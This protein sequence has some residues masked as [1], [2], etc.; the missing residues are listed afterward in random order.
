MTRQPTPC[1]RGPGPDAWPPLPE[2][3]RGVPSWVASSRSKSE[4]RTLLLLRVNRRARSDGHSHRWPWA[5]PRGDP[6]GDTQRRFRSRRSGEGQEGRT[7][8][9]SGKVRYSCSSWVLSAVLLRFLTSRCNSICRCWVA[10]TP[11]NGAPGADAPSPRPAH[12]PSCCLRA[13][14]P[15]SASVGRPAEVPV[16]GRACCRVPPSCSAWETRE[17]RWQ[18]R[19]APPTPPPRT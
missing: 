1:E 19:G 15:P 3:A 7:D 17:P 5:P 6:L 12:P 9:A 14:R 4:L 11:P 13:P 18:P 10:D 16:L 8:A 2:A